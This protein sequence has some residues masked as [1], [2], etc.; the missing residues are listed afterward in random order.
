MVSVSP[1]LFILSCY[2]ID[3]YN[4]MFIYIPFIPD[5]RSYTIIKSCSHNHYLCTQCRY[6]QIYTNLS[7]PNVL[8]ITKKSLYYAISYY[9][10]SF[11]IISYSIISYYTIQSYHFVSNQ[12]YHFIP[13]CMLSYHIILYQINHI[14]IISCHFISNRMISH[15]IVS[16]HIISYHIISYHI[17]W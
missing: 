16:H 7:H 9:I 14:N 15:C 4:A 5:N 6:H 3:N 1:V 12:S 13:N 17:I 8:H 2:H 11:Y 10:I